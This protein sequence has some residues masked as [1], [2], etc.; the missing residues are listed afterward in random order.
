M[1]RNVSVPS[2][3]APAGPSGPPTPP[4]GR[5]PAPA[6]GDL[7]R[8]PAVTL[9]PA[10]D[11]RMTQLVQGGGYGSALTDRMDRVIHYLDS[12]PRVE[13]TCGPR[14]PNVVEV[15]RQLREEGAA[16]ARPSP[17]R[18]TGQGASVAAGG[19]IPLVGGV[20]NMVVGF[21]RA[22]ERGDRLYEAAQREGQWNDCTNG[23]TQR[24]EATRREV[25]ELGYYADWSV[26]LEHGLPAGVDLAR[27]QTDQGYRD[28][29]RSGISHRR[30][31]LVNGEA[32]P[33]AAPATPPT[34]P[35]RP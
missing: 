3:P 32:P 6:A 28:G 20:V 14:P 7:A 8:Q 29:I 2:D 13:S 11:A 17:A 34:A 15:Q 23:E 10:P 1:N 9:E 33:S 24:R 5:G 16:Q 21:A 25:G 26:T 18:L 4:A 30:N 31:A 27:L 22:L 35:R 12:L 19:A